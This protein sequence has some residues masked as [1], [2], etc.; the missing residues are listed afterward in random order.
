MIISTNVE[1]ALSEFQDL[2]SRATE[3]LNEDA[4]A[5]PDYYMGRTATKLEDDVINSLNVVARGTAFEETIEKVSGQRFPDIVAAKHYGV[6]VK[7]S[8][9]NRWIGL[10]GSVNE[11]TRVEDVSRIF[12]IF[13]KLIDPIEF[14]SRPYEDVLSEVVVT[15]YP[16]YKIEMNL[17]EGETI[18]DKM[19]TTYDE[20]RTSGNTTERI[21]EHYRSQLR[22]GESLWWIGDLK[23]EDSSS[24]AP[25]KTRFWRTLSGGEKASLLANGY[26]LFPELLSNS[27]KKYERFTLWL[28]YSH[29]VV[30]HSIRDDFSA[31]GQGELRTVLKD[32][33]EVPRVIMNISTSVEPIAE[34]ISIT[35]ESILRDAWEV[36]EI[37]SNRVSQWIDIIDALCSKKH[38]E[39][40]EMLAD[41]FG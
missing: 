1:P 40:K 9:D 7:R 20:L 27:R 2:V 4:K 12:I 3:Y 14:R 30:S 18:F 17:P 28:L 38:P 22:D 36:D 24:A 26:A 34:I 25:M 16:R 6:E 11:S 41:L 19:N 39:Y 10:G 5:R 13:G 21:V 33:G 8:K 35:D 29:G 37:S 32:Y 23:Q 15:H 31:G